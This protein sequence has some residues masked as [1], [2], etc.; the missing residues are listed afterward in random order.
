MKGYSETDAATFFI[1]D[2]LSISSIYQ[3]RYRAKNIFGWSEYSDTS[4]IKTIMQP[5]PVASVS[6]TQEGTNVIFTWAIPNAR[7]ASITHYNLMVAANS[8]DLVQHETYCNFVATNSCSFPMDVLNDPDGA[9][10]LS[11]GASIQV[12]VSSTNEHGT[13]DW[14]QLTTVSVFVQSV[15]ETPLEQPSRVDSLS[16]VNTITVLLPEVADFSLQAGGAQI[17][18]YNLEY[19]QGLGS[20]Y[21]EVTGETQEQLLTQITVSTTPGL[22]YSFRYRLKNIFGFSQHYSPPVEIKSATA[23][24]A[25]TDL[26]SEVSGRNVRISWAAASD[27]FDPLTRFEVEIQDK[28]GTWISETTTC[29]GADETIRTNAE[30]FVPLLTLISSNYLL[31]QGDRVNIRVAATNKM[32]TSAYTQIEG[33]PVETVPLKPPAVTQGDQTTD[34]QIH[35]TWN[36][37]VTLTETGGSPI[38]SYRL[39]WDDRSDK[40]VWYTLVGYDSAYLGLTW[41]QTGALP[42]ETYSFRMQ[43]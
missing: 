27:N 31:E 43:V 22:T 5:E 21:F 16:Q 24:D 12:V 37:I 17:T 41:V 6:S 35:V 30:C 26:L 40:T 32:G 7:G 3:V 19:N 2:S 1:Q 10:A 34:T 18:S 15:P 4:Q 38:L 36:E 20:D 14:S 9:F 28:A 23:P 29:D 13:S 25:P 8:G 39:D 11:L 42:G 33:V